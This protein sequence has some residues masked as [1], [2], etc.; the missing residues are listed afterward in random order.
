MSQL[1]AFILEMKERL[2]I[3]PIS[4]SREGFMTNRVRQ[5]DLRWVGKV[6]SRERLTI[7]IMAG[8]I[9]NLISLATGGN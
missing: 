9:E 2:E 6:P 4:L 5:E 1:H 8:V 7:E 3:D